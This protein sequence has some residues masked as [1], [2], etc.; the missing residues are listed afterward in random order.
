[1]CYANFIIFLLT[2]QDLF[3]YTEK[4]FSIFKKMNPTP[5]DIGQVIRRLRKEKGFTLAKTAELCKCSSSLLSQIET[6]TVNPSLSALK[7]ISDA[8]DIPMASLFEASLAKSDI[9]I[10]LMEAKE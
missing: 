9:S 7:A 4:N 10:S 1:M 6:G 3:K 5:S 8:L 2:C